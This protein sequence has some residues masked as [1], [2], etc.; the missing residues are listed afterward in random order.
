MDS[1]SQN[2]DNVPVPARTDESGLDQ[3]RSAHELAE[4]AQIHLWRSVRTALKA[5]VHVRTIATELGIDRATVYR[6]LR[7]YADG[8]ATD[9]E[10]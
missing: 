6:R 5:G 8:A 4:S 7:R 3:V 1:P 2:C 9:E 10:S